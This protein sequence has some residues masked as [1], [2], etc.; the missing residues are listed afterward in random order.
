MELCGSPDL[1]C[2][3]QSPPSAPVIT[4]ADYLDDDQIEEWISKLRQE[5]EG[6]RISLSGPSVMHSS[7]PH[8]PTTDHPGFRYHHHVQSQPNGSEYLKAAAK[9]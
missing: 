2:P 4:P 7:T 8:L 6:G 9:I 1:S 5:E 3:G